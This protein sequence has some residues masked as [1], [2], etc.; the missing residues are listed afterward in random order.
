MK[1]NALVVGL[2]GELNMFTV[3]RAS[4]LLGGTRKGGDA[5]IRGERT[6]SNVLR[7]AKGTPQRQQGPAAFLKGGSYGAVGEHQQHRN[8]DS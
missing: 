1:N 4:A 6:I 5:G 2:S 8:K 3:V 7:L